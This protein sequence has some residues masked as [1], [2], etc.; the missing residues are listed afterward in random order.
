MGKAAVGILM[1]E[2]S[3]PR[4][5]GDIGNASTWD[6]PVMMRQVG[7]ASAQK[8]VHENPHALFDAFVGVGRELIAE[9]CVGL[10][11]SCGFLSLMQDALKEALGVPFA[12]SSLMQLPMVE[13]TLPTGQE[14]GILTISEESLSAAHLRAA[15]ARENTPIAGLPRDG[16]F[17]G[18]IFDNRP[19]MNLDACR[20]EILA[21]AKRLAARNTSV[22]AVVLECTNMAPYA[23]DISNLTGLPVYSI[24]SFLNWF[25]AGLAPPP[26]QA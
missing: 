6:F 1:L 25:Q 5:L 17:A 4:P 11:T 19:E 9:G 22:G 20:S 3:F 23:A 13:A 15:G 2:T 16:A 18:A 7:G 12:S 24:V 8:V 26:F 21:A 10:T 14:A